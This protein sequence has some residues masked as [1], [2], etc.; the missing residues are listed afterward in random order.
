MLSVLEFI[1][2]SFKW[3]LY[4]HEMLLLL[5]AFICCIQSTIISG[6]MKLMS[7]CVTNEEH[8]LCFCRNQQ[9]KIQQL[10]S[11]LQN[12]TQQDEQMIARSAHHLMTS[13]I[14]WWTVCISL[15]LITIDFIEWHLSWR[16]P[17]VG[18]DSINDIHINERNSDIRI[19]TVSAFADFN[20]TILSLS[21]ATA[22][23]NHSALYVL[24][25]VQWV[26]LHHYHSV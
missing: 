10:T 21:V 11:K 20:R 6:Q 13:L 12:L 24:Y 18:S 4:Y 23:V 25:F 15:F 22:L 1:I 7:C 5:C 9:S 8:A 17:C 3:N 16:L 2:L 19:M 26:T 14:C